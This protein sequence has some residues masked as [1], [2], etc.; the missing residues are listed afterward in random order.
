LIAAPEAAAPA[1][2]EAYGDFLAWLIDERRVSPHTHLAY[3]RDVGA[4]IAFIAEHRGE[5]VDFS[6][7]AD[8][9]ASDLHAWLARNRAH[10]LVAASNARTLSGVK[11]FFRWAARRKLFANPRV[12]AF[13]GP[14]LPRGLPKPLSVDDAREVIRAVADGHAETW[15]K[16]RD[17]AVFTLL[18]GAG[19]RIDEAL[20]LNRDV[21][22]LGE[23][24]RVL[25]K[26]RKERVLPLLPAVREAIE[27]YIRLCPHVGGVRSPLF[28]AVRGGR[29][30]A[31]YVE[32]RMRA[33]RAELG[34]PDH[35]TPHAL[36]HSFATHLLTAG[37]DLRVIQELLGH[38]S[39]ATT[40]RYTDVDAARL[41]EVYANAHPRART[42]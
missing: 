16:A 7:L 12:T 28:R 4:F 21:L 23:S 32:K 13:R 26:G 1:L 37:G 6:T 9:R 34:L 10:G 19:L 15:I 27:Q 18:Y 40:Q 31:T 25:G 17:T 5:R 20:S 8:L 42:R 11:T 35:A 36:R 14:K 33:V 41:L 3:G 30:G 22:P 38:S 24:L 39:L 29:L 2:L